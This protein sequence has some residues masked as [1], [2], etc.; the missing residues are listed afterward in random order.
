MEESNNEG[1]AKGH[2]RLSKNTRFTR[3]YIPH[4][5]PE[6]RR[7]AWSRGNVMTSL[8][9]AMTTRQGEKVS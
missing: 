8:S 7:Q 2:L 1:F 3:E 5:V 4:L 6:G 9:F